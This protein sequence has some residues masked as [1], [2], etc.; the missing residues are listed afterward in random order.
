MADGE[1]LRHIGTAVEHAH[2][3]R[4]L[5]LKGCSL[6]KPLV[7]VAWVTAVHHSDELGARNPQTG[8]ERL[9]G[10]DR[11]QRQSPLIRHEQASV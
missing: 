11:L 9:L 10:T 6:E 7:T 4:G 3:L 1:H 5:R 2:H 8:A